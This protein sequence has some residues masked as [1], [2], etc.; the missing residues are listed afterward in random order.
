MVEPKR[1]NLSGE[2]NHDK[3][4]DGAEPKHPSRKKQAPELI[5]DR[6]RIFPPEDQP[7]LRQ[8]YQVKDH[9]AVGLHNVP[10]EGHE[11][12]E[13]L[14]LGAGQV[15]DGVQE[16]DDGNPEE[17]VPA[18]DRHEAIPKHP[19]QVAAEVLE[20]DDAVEQQSVDDVDAE[21]GA[22]DQHLGGV[23]DVKA[24]EPCR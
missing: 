23:Q 17:G 9:E 22:D 11:V 4:V 19:L 12:A 8:G 13:K 20:P 16:V 14:W 10:D 18:A 6:S 3:V 2:I 5:V 1:T 15:V 7:V 21:R 24:A